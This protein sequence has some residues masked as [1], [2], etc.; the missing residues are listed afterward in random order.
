MPIIVGTG[1]LFPNFSARLA[2]CSLAILSFVEEKMISSISFVMVLFPLVADS[3]MAFF[4][5]EGA[6]SGFLGGG[7]SVLARVS[8]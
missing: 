4:V 7:V 2:I 1:L 3:R 6:D 8:S 5:E